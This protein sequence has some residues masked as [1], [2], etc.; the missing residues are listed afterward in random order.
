MKRSLRQLTATLSAFSLFAAGTEA[1]ADSKQA[2]AAAY[3]TTQTSRAQGKLVAAR[4]Q[5]LACSAATCSAYVI[6]DCARWL[7]EIDA[8]LPTVVFTAVDATGANTA[9]VRVTVDFDVLAEQLD[10]KAVPIDPGEHVVRFDMEGAPAIEE[11][12]LIREGEKNR[13]LAASFKKA[14]PVVPP[15][16][17]LPPALASAPDSGGVPTWAWLSGAG[18]LVLLGVGAGFGVS[19]LDAHGSLTAKCGG[20]PALC[21]VSTKAETVPLAEQRDLNRSV[22]LGL[23]AAGVLAIG[24]AVIG[25]VRAPSKTSSQHASFVLV[26]VG[27]PSGGG[28]QI[29]GQF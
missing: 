19:A 8:M 2:C 9:A 22:F 27:S 11:N 5:A 4:K 1:W 26:P 7:A 15:S 29:M 6:K 10:G 13:T 21:P 14:S 18:G 12:V 23:G 3:E 25:I 24:A 20:N 17:P 16:A 28:A